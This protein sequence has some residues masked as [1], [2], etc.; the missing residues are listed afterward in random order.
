MWGAALCSRAGWSLLSTAC[1]PQEQ[2][3]LRR[4]SIVLFGNLTKFS[5]GHGEVFLEQILNGLVTLLLHLQDPRP[6]VVK[7]SVPA[8]HHRLLGPGGEDPAGC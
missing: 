6:E 5:E 3:D 2:P 7:V 8:S 1:P 4:S